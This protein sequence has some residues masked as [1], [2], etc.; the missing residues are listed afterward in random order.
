MHGKIQYQEFTFC[1][2]DLLGNVSAPAHNDWIFNFYN[3]AIKRLP[4]QPLQLVCQ[5]NA[6][7]V[8]RD[9]QIGLV[10]G[11]EL[12]HLQPLGPMNPGHHPAKR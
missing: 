9:C 5:S 2:A 1:L 6:L 10:T 3:S 12:K 8:V 4:H 11:N 7:N